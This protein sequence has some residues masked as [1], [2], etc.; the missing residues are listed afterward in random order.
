METKINMVSFDVQQTTNNQM[1]GTYRH[2]ERVDEVHKNPNIIQSQSHLN[3]HFKQ[4][5][6]D[7]GNAISYAQAYKNMIDK[8]TIVERGLRD[9]ATRLTNLIFDVNSDYF[10]QNGGHEFAKKYFTDAYNL[11]C[12]MAGG[13]R[14]IVSAVIHADE[15]NLEATERIGTAYYKK[16]KDGTKEIDIPK[17]IKKGEP[18]WH[19]HMHVTT[20]PV[21]EKKIKFRKG[22]E[23]AGEVKEVIAQVSHSK[24]WGGLAYIDTGDVDNK[25]KPIM[26]RVT[27]YS[28]AWDKYADHMKDKGYEVERG[29]KN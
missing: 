26:E 8:G 7:N 18:V 10:H 21:V 17:T 3:F 24:K 11:A 28:K 16:N 23:R 25:G 1:G 5:L 15:I 9:D 29:V 6:D 22:H 2:N 13:E 19:Y 4:C 12:E 14:Y 20:V 27:G